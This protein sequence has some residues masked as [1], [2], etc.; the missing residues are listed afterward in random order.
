MARLT[1]PRPLEAGDDRESFD[2]GRESLNQWFRRYAWRN[3]ETNISRVSVMCEAATG[4][5]A[6]YVSLSSGHIE[7][8]Y[9]PKSAQRNRPEHVPIFLL[10]QLAVDKRFQ[11]IGYARSLLYFA[12]RTSVSVS[13]EIGCFGVL[14]HPLDDEVRGF[15]KR[16]GFESLPYDPRQ[17]MIVRIKDLEH[18]GFADN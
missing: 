9:L 17:S 11:G 3:H 14:T 10:G 2:C 16:W 5:I 1:P 12:L 4:I 18:C 13:K 15:Y 8:E 6:G 7:R